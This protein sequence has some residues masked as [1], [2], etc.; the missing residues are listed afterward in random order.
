MMYKDLEAKEFLED[1][2]DQLDEAHDVTLLHFAKYQ[3]ALH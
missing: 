3:K 1:A 2:L